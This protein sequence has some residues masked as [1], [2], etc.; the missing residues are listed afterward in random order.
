MTRS[1]VDLVVTLVLLALT[2]SAAVALASGLVSFDLRDRVQ[3]ESDCDATIAE[4]GHL[5]GTWG[6]ALLALLALIVSGAQLARR[7]R[8]FPVALIALLAVPFAVAFGY[9]VQA[10]GVY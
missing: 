3:C 6:V 10:H 8:A 9:Y 7:R 5:I 2:I 4:V 1:R